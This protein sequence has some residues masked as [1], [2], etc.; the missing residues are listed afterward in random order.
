M[1]LP[2]AR[3]ISARSAA[4]RKY[5]NVFRL[6][7]RGVGRPHL[8]RRQHV[9]PDPRR[10][11]ERGRA[12]LAEVALDRLRA[13][14]AVGAEADR[15]A[16]EQRVD[17]VPRPRH[18]QVR[19]RRVVRHQPSLAA[20][21]LRGVDGVGVG[22]HG[23]LRVAGGA[24]G[25]AD[26]RDVVR[27]AL[28]DLGLEGAGMGLGVLPAR[29]L[30][31]VVGLEPVVAVVGHAARV[32]VDHEAQGRQ[33]AAEGQHL[34]D[35]LLVLGDD[36]AHLGVVPDVGQL[37]RDRVL[38]HGNGHAP[39]ALGGHLGP[40]EPRP[41]VADDGQPVAP[42]EAERGQPQGEGAHLVEVLAPRPRL[43]D[44]AVLLAD[45]RPGA[46]VA[47]VPQ[48]QARK[49]RRLSHVS[50]HWPWDLRDRP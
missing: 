32:V 37:L 43:P 40:V 31:G 33:L 39:Q 22:E 21:R 26:D 50:L 2:S 48:Q 14:R 49:R 7:G 13:L 30:D 9:L 34:V 24:G 45:R 36:H 6:S 28:L 27:L 46:Q 18:R 11:E 10:G 42:A 41:V 35:L 19:Q 4:E 29:L 5:S 15:E 3:R 44:P 17:R 23:A 16:R 12:E 8:D 47:R 38:V 25:V 1:G 20:E